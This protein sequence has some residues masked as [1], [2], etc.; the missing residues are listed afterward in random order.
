MSKSTSSIIQII[1]LIWA[2]SASVSAAHFYVQ[3]DAN[4]RALGWYQTN[5]IL[6]D[7][8]LNYGNG[9]VEWHNGTVLALNSTAFD[10]LVATVPDLNYTTSEYGIFIEGINGV[11]NETHYWAVY[12]NG[13]YAP[14]GVLDLQLVQ[15]DVLYLNHEVI[16]W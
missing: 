14:V 6:I 2:I 16:S 15:G 9:T 12:L 1:L 13:D 5:T 8:G 3:N 7:I 11:Q 10:A 4:S